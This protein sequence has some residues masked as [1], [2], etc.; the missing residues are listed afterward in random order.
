MATTGP[1]VTL[2]PLTDPGAL[3]QEWLAL[4][5]RS[6]HS[7]FQSWTWIGCWLRMLPASIRPLVLRA[8]VGDAVVGLGVLVPHRT[9]RHGLV[10]ANGLHLHATGR[11][12]LDQLTIEHNGLLVDRSGRDEII[13]ASV[14][15]LAGL[16][17]F[18]ELHFPGVPDPYPDLCA[19]TSLRLDVSKTAPSH[20]V[21]LAA[22]AQGGYEPLLS[23]N[24][25]QQIRRAVRLYGGD[26]LS[27][28]VARDDDQATDFLDGLKRLHQAYWTA[29]GRPG[30]F[31]NPFFTRFHTTL[32]RAAL[33]SGEVEI[34]RIASA[35]RT[36]GYL[37]NF[38]SR[39]HV[40]NYQSGFDYDPDNRLKPGLV[41]HAL[42]IGHHLAE[43]CE[44]YDFLAGDDRYK[45][46]LG[47]RTGRLFWLTLQRPRLSFALERALRSSYRRMRPSH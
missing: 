27:Y 2:R 39:G 34:A 11:A 24:T 16:R 45:R 41:S 10:V 35:E 37:Y 31:A 40:C 19:Q 47:T 6:D 7:F 9:V 44:V 12:G 21:D 17:R 26:S 28:C 30:A 38:K 3:A 1:D 23:K 42:A 14:A 15:H 13:A 36:L 32:L 8:S 43:G 46:S 5:A 4:Q 25:R 20:Y 29:R 18:D 33:P 22:A